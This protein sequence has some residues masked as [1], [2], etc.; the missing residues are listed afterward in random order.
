[1]ANTKQKRILLIKPKHLGDTI[2]LTAAINSLPPEW[3]VDLYLLSDSV[4]LARPIPRV[5]EVFFSRKR[6]GIFK[7]LAWDIQSII[8]MR[9]HQYDAAVSLSDH[10]KNA[11]L[12]LASGAKYR[13]TRHSA[14][15]NY[16]WHCLFH[17]SIFAPPGHSALQDLAVIRGVPEL[18]HLQPSPY[19]LR[20]SPG[21]Q[22]DE[23]NGPPKY[24]L[25]GAVARWK[26]KEIP[27]SVWDSVIEGIRSRGY[28]VYLVGDANAAPRYADLAALSDS[29]VHLFVGRSYDEL[30]RLVAGASAVLSV[31]SMIVHM[32]SAARRPV[33]AIFGPTKPTVWGPWKTKF[34]VV[35]QSDKFPCMPCDRDGC[36][37]SKVSECLRSLTPTIII[38]EFDQLTSEFSTDLLK[39]T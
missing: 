38:R 37:G 31:D 7:K 21:P 27:F 16:L 17:R 22:S 25:I 24:V 26:F 34:R 32:A 30:Y 20:P 36:N 18:S 8:R 28:V 13:I 1:M 4:E 15:R 2:I 14:R 19:C 9:H 3:I 39:E 11:L 33:A 29:G 10:P 5:K 12:A 35:S 6:E 23:L